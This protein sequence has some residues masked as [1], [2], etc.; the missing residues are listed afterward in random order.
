LFHARAWRAGSIPWNRGH[1]G[2]AAGDGFRPC[3]TGAACRSPGWAVG[4]PRGRRFDKCRRLRGDAQRGPGS[5]DPP[6]S[7]AQA[8]T[9]V[10][11]VELAH[12]PR[13]RGCSR[14]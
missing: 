7:M 14:R 11:D 6:G 8:S 12:A 5:G 10:E 1:A 9:C 2:E 13:L 3:E 4:R